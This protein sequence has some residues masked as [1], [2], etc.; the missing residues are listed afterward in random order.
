MKNK[1]LMEHF[2]IVEDP[3]LD[4]MKQ[5]KLI[6]ILV[7]SVCAILSGFDDFS[8]IADYAR[9]KK[10]WFKTFL[11]LPNGIPSHDT[12]G[13]V[14]SLIDPDSFAQAF[15]EWL[16]SIK[17]IPDL[18]EVISI[19]GKFLRGALRQAGR[20]KSAVAIVSAWAHE[21]G[22]CLGQKK[23][24]MKKEEG[25][26]YA[27]ES[28]LDKLYIK[29]CIVTLD[30]GGATPQIAQKIVKNGGD[31]L[32]GLK[33]NQGTIFEYA[34]LA[35]KNNIAPS[36]SFK[37]EEKSHGRKEI[38]EYAQININDIDFQSMP[39]NFFNILIDKWQDLGSF[40]Q[41]KASREV[42]GEKSEE[43][44]WYFSSLK[45]NVAEA[46]RAIRAH[47]GIENNLHHVLDVTFKEDHMR[48]RLQHAAENMAFLRRMAINMLKKKDPTMSFKRKRHRCNWSNEY[49][50][51]TLFAQIE[52]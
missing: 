2:S 16:N 21:A 52:N 26:K 18:R 20:S 33:G 38:R 41:V 30:A 17:D 4:R 28:I 37:T 13:R 22:L 14:F 8:E 6:D 36:S 47:W 35:F 44:R 43:T 48:M 9:E 15:M 32:I 31:Y 27:M 42:R 46:A 23:F 1:T 5:H 25:E 29:G 24:E 12:F 45:D 19:D 3:R 10:E 34:Q 7:M 40:I 11:E 50:E 51:D 49:L 39:E